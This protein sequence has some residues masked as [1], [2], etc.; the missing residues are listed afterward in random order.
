MGEKYPIQYE[1]EPQTVSAGMRWLT[2]SLKNIG[3]ENLIGLDVKLN[4][5]DAYNIYVYGTGTYVAVIKPGETETVP[6]QML[7]NSTGMLYAS[8][9]GWKGAGLFHWESPRMEVAV[10]QDAAKLMSLFALTE[11]YPLIGARIKFEATIKGASS[12]E[13]LRL[14]LWAETPSGELKELST[15]VVKE[16]DPGQEAHYAA[17]VTPEEEGMYTIYAYLYDRTKRIGQEWER[18]YVRQA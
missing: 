8:A 11:P 18:I 9:D 12:S 2:L 3:L 15:V 1:L 14:E 6:F 4:S 10:G 16:L 5:L 17:E 13:D 7:A